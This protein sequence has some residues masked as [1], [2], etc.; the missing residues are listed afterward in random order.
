MYENT[1]QKIFNIRINLSL[2]CLK[3][4][5]FYT[6]EDKFYKT[7]GTLLDYFGVYNPRRSPLTSQHIICSSV[8]FIITLHCAL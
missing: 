7:T 3:C 5:V 8:D 4:P 6:V 1:F 2:R